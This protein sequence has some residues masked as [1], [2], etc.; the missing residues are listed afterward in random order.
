MTEKHH[1]HHVHHEAHAHSKKKVSWKKVSITLGI[2][3]LVVIGIVFLTKLGSSGVSDGDKVKLDYTIKTESGEVVDQSTATVTVGKI[4]STLGFASDEIDK[5]LIAGNKNEVTINLQA[6]DA[7]GEYDPSLVSIVNRTEV[8]K[9]TQEINRTFE[10]AVSVFKSTFNADPEVGKT[11]ELD[12]AVWN[13]SVTDIGT[14][15]VTMSQNPSVGKFVPINEL[16]F[17][18]I[19]SVTS[20]QIIMVY[21]TEQTSQEIPSGK[22]DI[23]K[24]SQN[25]YFKLTPIIGSTITLGYGSAKV[26]DFNETSVVL[27]YNTLYAGED[28]TVELKLS[29]TE[30]PKTIKKIVS[31]G[32]NSGPTLQAFVMTHCPFGT[33]MEKGILPVYQLLGDKANFEIRFVSYTMHGEKE[34][35]ETK[36]Q[37]CIREETNEFWNYLACFLEDETYA[38]KCM[39]ENN[40]DESKI[41]EC[42]T[43]RAEEYWAEDKELNTQY[44]V[45]GS[46]T[47][48][49]DGTNVEIYPRS[50][51]DV[52]KAVCEAF[53][54]APAEC[55]ETLDT[56]NPSPGFGYSTSTASGSA[57][58]G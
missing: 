10:I 36:R 47:N 37:L 35:E 51:E 4:Y 49:L 14:E 33:Q 11:Y 42:M 21:D 45:Q 12:G 53:S 6:K 58:C 15:K 17:A 18:N 7:F 22:L 27:D 5:Q 40:I 39:K 29:S 3:I 41:T 19:T 34:D 2:I 50:P 28:L 16:L 23:S 20:T 54:S 55:S 57:Q 46:P 13:Y 26:L 32:A 38:S 1:E 44:D 8:L 24:D 9:R 31:S 30:K 56:A 43:S 48:V 52:K 25:I